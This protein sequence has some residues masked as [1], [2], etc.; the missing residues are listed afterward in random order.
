MAIRWPSTATT[1]GSSMSGSTKARRRCIVVDLGRQR[2]QLLDGGRTVLEALVSTARNGPGERRDS[3]CTPRGW[4]VVRARI[5]DGLP[6]GAVLRGR[7]PTGECFVPG[8]MDPRQDWILSRILWL[9]GREPGVNR[10][11]DVDTQRRYIY[12][13]GT[14]DLAGLGRPVSHGCIR[15]ANQDIIG[16]FG[17]VA[18]GDAVYIGRDAAVV[19]RRWREGLRHVP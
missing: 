8:R 13:H 19:A 10:L 12:I 15:M 2:L 18:V 4:H 16:L 6:P 11:G 3:A 17:R 14:A 7:R 9:G 1:T 5:G